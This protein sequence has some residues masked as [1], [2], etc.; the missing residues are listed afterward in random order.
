MVRFKHLSHTYYQ[1]F[2]TFLVNLELPEHK[3]MWEHSSAT[4]MCFTELKKSSFSSL[5]RCHIWAFGACWAFLLW[6]LPP[7]RYHGFTSH[8]RFL[9][10]GEMRKEWLDFSLST[11]SKRH[12]VCCDYF[13]LDTEP[14]KQPKWVSA[15]FVKIWGWFCSWRHKKT[16]DILKEVEKCWKTRKAFLISWQVSGASL[17]CIKFS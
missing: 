16:S 5:F 8:H 14:N 3:D 12:S 10:S 17:S 11:V 13:S 2:Q 6:L 4:Q 1:R 9:Q 15:A 7:H